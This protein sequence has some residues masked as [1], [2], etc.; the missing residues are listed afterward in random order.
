[1]RSGN[2]YF[3]YYLIEATNRVRITLP[4]FKEYYQKKKNEVPKH[5]HKRALV[6]TGR[7]FVRL[8]DVLLRNGQLYQPTK[9]VIEK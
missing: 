7:K 1:N 3:R 8:I 5:K 6:L 2:R 9:V 4:E